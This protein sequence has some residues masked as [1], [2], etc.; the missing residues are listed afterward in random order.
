MVKLAK[1]YLNSGTAD[2]HG[3]REH[4]RKKGCQAD[5]KAQLR[6]YPLGEGPIANANM[7]VC[8]YI[9]HVFLNAPMGMGDGVL[10]G[11]FFLKEK[12]SNSGNI[13]IHTGLRQLTQSHIT[14]AET[15]Q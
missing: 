1:S 11:T 2:E 4:A 9:K 15:N 6:R 10:F 13:H 3:V 14:I 5:A 7:C 12:K 8:K